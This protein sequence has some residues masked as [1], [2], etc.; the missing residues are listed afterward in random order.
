MI[1]IVDE[2]TEEEKI[3]PVIKDTE[4]NL[5]TLGRFIK[6]GSRN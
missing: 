5:K 3:V 2:K 1:T 6:N 4:K